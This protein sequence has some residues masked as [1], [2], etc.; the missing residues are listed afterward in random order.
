M[1]L[2]KPV[3]PGEAEISL[4]GA[5]VTSQTCANPALA[6]DDDPAT[7]AVFGAQVSGYGLQ[8]DYYSDTNFEHLLV[9]QVSALPN[10]MQPSLPPPDVG[11]VFSAR[12]TGF[13]QP[14]YSEDYTFFTSIPQGSIRVWIN[15]VQIP[16][17]NRNPATS[18]QAV[19]MTAGALVALRI[20]FQAPYGID[21]MAGGGNAASISFEWASISQAD[22]AIPPT[23]F[24]THS[25]PTYASRFLRV[26][27][28]YDVFLSRIRLA[29]SGSGASGVGVD[30]KSSLGF[31]EG[32]PIP[33]D[34]ALTYIPA[35][36][37]GGVHEV[38]FSPPVL[39]RGIAFYPDALL[40]AP[41]GQPV[42]LSHLQVYQDIDTSQGASSMPKPTVT[43]ARVGCSGAVITPRAANVA[44]S[45]P[46]PQALATTLQSIQSLTFGT[47]SKLARETGG[48]TVHQINGYETDREIKGKLSVQ[49]HDYLVLQSLQNGTL[50]VNPV[51]GQLQETQYF[52]PGY[53]DRNPYFSLVAQSANGD[54][55][56]L[57][58]LPKCKLE[59]NLSQ[60]LERDKTTTLE[61]DF[62]LF[63]DFNYT[64]QDGTVGGIY[65]QIFNNGGATAIHS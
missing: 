14:A 65:E 25:P 28:G 48:D 55:N 10:V 46:F 9:S 60:N 19:K 39:A 38:L 23:A 40:P 57:F 54:P 4:T 33:N 22:R 64:R 32:L 34:V 2:D 61:I 44:T 63:W 13:I 41:T 29:Y 12:W 24:F 50:V 45:Y 11:K 8:E 58:V 21:F 52:A 51:N 43:Q 62:T 36:A 47:M 26:D 18:S 3:Y 31:H 17:D 59:G 42:T 49:R 7:A 1:P 16:F 6:L 30:Y 5:A 35:P 20:D 56:A 15:G 53:A 37:D 27:W